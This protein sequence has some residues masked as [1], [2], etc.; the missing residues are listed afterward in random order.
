MW[1]KLVIQYP[2]IIPSP[3]VLSRSN[4]KLKIRAVLIFEDNGRNICIRIS[5]Q[6]CQ[7]QSWKDAQQR[8][9]SVKRFNQFLHSGTSNMAMKL[10]NI[11]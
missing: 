1:L 5:C 7:K 10:K 11:K 3:Y 6:L 4:D 9:F 2:P 8:E